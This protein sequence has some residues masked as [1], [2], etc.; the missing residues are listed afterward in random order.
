MIN[1][2]QPQPD[3]TIESMVAVSTLWN[4]EPVSGNANR[5]FVESTLRRMRGF[6]TPHLMTTYMV[7][8][9]HWYAQAMALLERH[10]FFVLL[11][12]FICGDSY[13]MLSADLLVGRRPSTMH[14]ITSRNKIRCALHFCPTCVDSELA[15][16]GY[17]YTHRSHQVAGVYVCA[18]H[19]LG[20]RR[21]LPDGRDWFVAHGALTRFPMNSVELTGAGGVDLD[22]LQSYSEFVAAALDGT[23][24]AV[25][26]ATRLALCHRQL[27]GKSRL[28]NTS[29][30]LREV[31]RSAARRWGSRFLEEVGVPWFSGKPM[32]YGDP[33][34]SNGRD[35][36]AFGIGF[37]LLA[38]FFRRPH[39]F[40]QATYEPFDD[41]PKAS[42]TTRVQP[43]VTDG[44]AMLA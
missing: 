23:L 42:E 3:Q 2:L 12:P 44:E 20:L 31:Y 17:A 25:S 39:E 34:V 29:L 1:V 10:A 16:L 37:V 9:R 15:A 35:A 22:H 24:P 21:L 38:S 13:E 18:R 40:R 43:Q 36:S 6:C 33:V 26:Y 30:E 19:G 41:G 5:Q 11:K 14:V 7:L 28:F 4:G 8:G 32:F 27:T